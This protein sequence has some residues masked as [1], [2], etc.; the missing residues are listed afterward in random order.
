MWNLTYPLLMLKHLWQEALEQ[1]DGDALLNLIVQMEHLVLQDQGVQDA[2]NSSV[3]EVGLEDG[4]HRAAVKIAGELARA[5]GA[6][7]H[8]PR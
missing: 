2:L 8:S 6:G 4:I 5:V 1:Q 3:G 7:R